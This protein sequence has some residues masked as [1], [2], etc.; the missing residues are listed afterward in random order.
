MRYIILLI[1][2]LGGGWLLWQK[3][4]TTLEYASDY[5]NAAYT[6]E[7]KRVQLV[8]GAAEAEGVITQE[9]GNE[10]M[11]DFSGD[12][13]ADVAFILAQQ[14]GGTGT[15]YYIAVARGAEGGYV[16]TNALLLGDRIAPQTTE[17]RDGAIIVNY[18]DRKPGEPMT[19]DPS[20][21]VSRTFRMESGIL[22]EITQ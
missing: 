18:A 15:F 10:V 5:G 21:G 6:I 8:E 2:V 12:G 4:D 1:V 22:K 3:G 19:A 16:G 14:P 7:G 17:I 20:V 11:G 13:I 9:F